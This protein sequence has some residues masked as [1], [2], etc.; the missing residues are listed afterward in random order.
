MTHKTTH[1]NAEDEL[2]TSMERATILGH[3]GVDWSEISTY[4]MDGSISGDGFITITLLYFKIINS[5][6]HNTKLATCTCNYIHITTFI[7][8]QNITSLF[9]RGLCEIGLPNEV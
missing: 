7:F 3:R 6:Q 2:T 8:S 4:Y 5:N 9:S 1:T